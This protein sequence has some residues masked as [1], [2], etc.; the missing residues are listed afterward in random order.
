MKIQLNMF[1][2]LQQ[3]LKTLYEKVTKIE[4]RQ[5][6]MA[7]DIAEIKQFIRSRTEILTHPKDLPKLLLQSYTDSLHLENKIN[8]QEEKKDYVV[9]VKQLT[10]YLIFSGLYYYL[11]LRFR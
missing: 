4:H 7:I 6:N 11:C 1:L 10:N 2:G 3:V 9:S 8:Q 5:G